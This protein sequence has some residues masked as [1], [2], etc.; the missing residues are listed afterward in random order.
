M[1]FA[2]AKTKEQTRSDTNWAVQPPKMVR[3]LKFRIWEVEEL[4]CLSSE[5]KGPAQL[6]RT[7]VFTT[8]IV[9]FLYFPNSKFQ[10]SNHLL[11]LYSLV[12]VGPGRKP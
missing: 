6:I 8:Q 2:N 1:I 10:S 4:Y 12:C 11:W 5:N 7:F 3:G 9:Q